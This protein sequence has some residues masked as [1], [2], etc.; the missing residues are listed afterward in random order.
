M[1]VLVQNSCTSSGFV[2]D[3]R[4]ILCN[5]HG[6]THHSTVRVRK[7]GDSGEILSFAHTFLSFPWLLTRCVFSSEK[8]LATVQ[9]EGF[10]CDLA[11]LTVEDDKFWEVL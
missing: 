2:I 4:R 10:E 11:L 6:V 9:H 7:H 3:G 5:S 8:Y 1:L